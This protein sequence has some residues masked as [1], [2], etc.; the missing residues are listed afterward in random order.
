MG[1]GSTVDRRRLAELFEREQAEFSGR[2]PQSKRL[3]ER[4]GDALLGGVPMNWMTRWPGPFP[5]YGRGAGGSR[6]V[7]VDGHEYVDFCLG[8]TGAMTGHAPPATV[9]TVSEVAA[10]GLTTMLPTEDAIAVGGE[11]RRRF[12]LPVWQ[13][14]LTATDANR[15][16]VRLA[17]WLTG[18]AKILVF[19]WCYHGTV[20][21]TFAVLES[22]RVVPRPGN[23][24][25][26]CDPA[27]T[28]RVAEFNDV[29]GVADA[30]S[31][32]DVACVL[33]EPALTNIGIVLPQP[34]G[35]TRR[36]GS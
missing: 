4:A 5:L 3:H 16:A 19:N 17:R 14:A 29:A 8:D 15:F 21:E 7:D 13:F 27:V 30:L 6:I 2:H 26:P 36:C 9:Q 18:R 25:P 35:F 24:G 12:G 11:L 32:G 10:A 31:A 34:G 28:T 1:A 20:D 33:A 23:V 22:G